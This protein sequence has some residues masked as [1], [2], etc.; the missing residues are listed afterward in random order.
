MPGYCSDSSGV[1][2][3]SIGFITA[4][5]APVNKVHPVFPGDQG[6]VVTGLAISGG[7]SR[8]LS[9]ALGQLRAL[10]QLGLLEGLDALSTVSGGT[11]AASIYMFADAEPDTLLGGP[12]D[13]AKLDMAELGRTPPPLGA[14]GTTWT[15]T[16]ALRLK[17]L[18]VPLKLLWISTV[19]EAILQPFGLG[20]L[21]T[22]MAASKLAN[23]T[24]LTPRPGR[25][26]NFIMSGTVEA[27]EGCAASAESVVSLQMSPDYTGSPFYPN[28]TTVSYEVA[29][30]VSRPPLRN[31]LIGGG[32]VETFAFGSEQPMDGQSGDQDMH[33]QAPV[34]PFSLARAVG[35]SSA[36]F[37][38]EAS[39]AVGTLV[40]PQINIWPVT[41]AAHPGP[42]PAMSYQLGDG[43]NQ[44][45]T[46]LLALLQ[47]GA[48][49]VAVMINT[50]APLDTKVDFCEAPADFDCTGL[51]SYDMAD[52]FG[53]YSPGSVTMAFDTNNQIFDKRD[54]LPL[55]CELGKLRK[56]GKPLAVRETLMLVENTWWGIE[57]GRA[58]D[59]AFVLLD[60]SEEF[61]SRLPA[62]T[63][64]KL[65]SGSMMGELTDYPYF[66]TIFPNEDATALTN[67][68]VNLLA[69]QMEYTVMQNADMFKG[70]FQ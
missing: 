63:Q 32:L 56:A 14:V 43:A 15:G 39:K 47:R 54:L 31:V 30:G 6:R 65:K 67:V 46:G 51:V 41:S 50:Y 64:A 69:A 49:K 21:D 25:P 55:L 33:G 66:K 20:R 24:F 44:E 1:C 62:D 38:A 7:G 45:N 18:G 19:A 48:S 4:K 42:Q 11:W 60:K 36:A 57:G 70:L 9:S 13:P 61:E 8:S 12:T 37:A 26:R 23:E 52:K 2:Y 35:I 5:V 34:G 16:I 40:D 68:Q 17:A 59:V 28:D 10:H 27:P 22:F 3:K 58:V 29:S 53:Y